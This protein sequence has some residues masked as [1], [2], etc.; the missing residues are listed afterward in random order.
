MRFARLGQGDIFVWSKKI[1]RK[2]VLDCGN[3][4]VSTAQNIISG[5]IEDCINDDTNIRPV[6][7]RAIKSIIRTVCAEE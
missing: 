3:Y 1:C 6:G 5:R 4:L 2:E 7:K